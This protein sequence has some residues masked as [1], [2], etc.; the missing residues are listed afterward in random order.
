MRLNTH[1]PD[2]SARVAVGVARVDIARK[3]V[4]A[5]P[6]EWVCSERAR[7][8]AAVRASIVEAF[9]VAIACSG[10]E[11]PLPIALA[12][13]HPAINPIQ[14]RPNCSGVKRGFLG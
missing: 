12:D 11:N 1:R 10:Q 5:E 2:A 4:Q 7:P 6:V 13:D 3:E 9:I 14:R 8:V